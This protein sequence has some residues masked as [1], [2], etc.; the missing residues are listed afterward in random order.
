MG[1][2]EDVGEVQSEK[3]RWV[4]QLPRNPGETEDAQIVYTRLSSPPT[5]KSL[6]VRVILLCACWCEITYNMQEQ[7]KKASLVSS[8]E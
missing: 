5:H 3:E 6:G 2:G 8:H 1:S 7:R 4:H